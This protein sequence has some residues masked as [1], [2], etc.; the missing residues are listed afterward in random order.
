MRDGKEITAGGRYRLF[1]DKYSN[2]FEIE[3]VTAAD[4][5]N[6]LCMASNIEGEV[7]CEVT[8]TVTKPEGAAAVPDKKA[9]K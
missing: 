5:G 9:V 7:K 1:C 3:P 8:L 4:A 6:Y 2:T